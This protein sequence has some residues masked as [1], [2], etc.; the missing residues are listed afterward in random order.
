MNPLQRAARQ[1]K[2]GPT[3]SQLQPPWKIGQPLNREM[4]H[5]D[6]RTAI[7][8]GFKLSTWV[9]AAVTLKSSQAARV[10]WR[11][12]EKP[13]VRGTKTGKRADE[14][15]PAES[16]AGRALE[17][18]LEN[19]N[20]A[21]GRQDVVER[22]VQ[23]LELG[24]N[25]LYS[26]VFATNIRAGK[27]IPAEMWPMNPSAL[28]PI[29]SREKFIS[30]YDY[31]WD[32]IKRTLPAEEVLHLMY[33]DPANPYWGLGALQAAARVV[34]TDI[35]AVAWNRSIMDNRAIPDIV[36]T[37]DRPLSREEWENAR[38]E[39]RESY[40]GSENGRAPW[41]VGDGASIQMLSW[42]PTDMDYLEGR[43]FSREE[44]S[45]VFHVPPPLL[46]IMENATEANLDSSRKELWTSGLIPLLDNLRGVRNRRLVPY[47]GDRATLKIDYDT[48]EVEVL[49]EDVKLKADAL[50]ILTGCGMPLNQAMDYLDMDTDEVEGGDVGLVPATVM[51]I[52]M[53]V[54]LAEQQARMGEATIE[55]T[56]AGTE[57]T[58][59]PPKDP[60][61]QPAP[62]RAA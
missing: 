62:K 12:F 14:W 37:I 24:G 8:E 35:S 13:E 40:A 5:L 57:A 30:G 52:T 54:E 56:E 22:E 60:N 33:C 34:D 42:K 31:E 43:K 3:T 21:M 20:Q 4:R 10:P 1:I 41:V 15:V 2:G 59:N 11:A 32:G 25:A 17:D 47:F 44:I 26:L 49:R 38:R 58:L 53:A 16:D 46:G 55:S 7:S 51:P 48:S 29:A 27:K 23:H 36:F 50:K 39:V 45:S 19:P 6:T 61:K 18:L 28:R 9:Y